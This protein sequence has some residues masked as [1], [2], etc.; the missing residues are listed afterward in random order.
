MAEKHKQFK[1]AGV[2][3]YS[4]STDSH[5][6]HKAWHDAS[7]IICKIQY[8]I[9]IDPTGA[10]SRTSGMMIEKEGI[11]YRGTFLVN[12]EGK[13]RMAGIHDNNVGRDASE[14]FHRAEATQFVASHDGEVYPAKWRKGE[15]TSKSSTD[16][17]GEA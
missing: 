2:E 10:P 6:V 3:T 14:L 16:L 11:V 4:V 9:L 13:I 1:S 15:A 12:P 8:P 7:E 17:A 5:F